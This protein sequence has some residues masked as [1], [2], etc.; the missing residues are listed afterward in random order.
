MS[1]ASSLNFRVLIPIAWCF[2]TVLMSRLSGWS[3]LAEQ[4]PADGPVEG[5]RA[6][7]RTGRIGA[8]TYH[9]C[10]Y[11]CANDRGLQIGVSWPMRLGHKP[12][13]I[14]WD[15]FHHIGEDHMLFSQKVRLS[16]GKPTL[17]RAVFPGWVRYRMPLEM[18]PQRDESR[19]RKRR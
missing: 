9:S 10:L 18:R 13:F 4:Y 1:D 16:I 12:L 17:T 3:K 15:A 19:Q 8:I 11:F 5:E 7:L 6:L 2:L 14:P